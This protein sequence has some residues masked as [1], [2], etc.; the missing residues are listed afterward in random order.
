M[1]FLNS[2]YYRGYR[3]IKF[4]KFG[5]NLLLQEETEICSTWYWTL[6]LLQFPVALSVFG[7]GAARLYRESKRRRMC[8]N[9]EPVCEANIQWTGLQIAFCALC[10]IL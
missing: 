3:N 2:S 6:N 7:Y 8:G 5:V 4:V 1:L 9:S 10:G